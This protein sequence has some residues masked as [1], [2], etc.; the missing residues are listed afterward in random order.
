MIK[1]NYK[2]KQKT[3]ESSN[4]VD[5][6]SVTIKHPK[7]S[8]KLSKTIRQ[9]EKLSQIASGKRFNTPL[10][11]GKKSESFLNEK[12]VKIRKQVQTFEGYTS[13]YN[14]KILNFF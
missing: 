13:S 2:K 4:V 3:F 12:N 6:K 14:V 1:N 10:L 11:S 5:I 9:V 7:T 8:R